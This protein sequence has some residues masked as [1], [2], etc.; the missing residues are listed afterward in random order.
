MASL[1]SSI[2]RSIGRKSGSRLN[3]LCINEDETFQTML[4]QTGHI[5]YYLSHPQIKPW[6]KAIRPIPSNCIFLSGKEPRDQLKQDIQFDIILCQNRMIQFQLLWK[7]ARQLSCPTII[8]EN[9]LTIPEMN[10]HE[11]EALANQQYNV[12]VFHSEFL[13]N[14][15]G[16]ESSDDDTFVVPYGID[17]DIFNGWVGEDGKILTIVNNYAQKNSITGFN[18]WSEITNGLPVNPRGD[19]KD[20]SKPTKDIRELISLYQNASV[21]LNTSSWLSCPKVLL[22]AMAIG[23]P[24]VTTATTTIPEIIIDGVNGYISHDN[25]ELRKQLIF[26]LENPDKSREL[27]ENAR[28]TII[29]KF[30]IKD[31]ISF[32]NEAFEH[33]VGQTSSTMTLS[34]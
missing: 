25:L 13:T 9:N 16:F 3:I 11:S 28:K 21:F 22:E 31:F 23:C 17:T 27:G 33:T 18:T 8:A 26:L 6:N 2:L 32:W 15:W 19:T 1:F 20:F 30:G 29:E 5:F 14:S 7:I 10:P 4:A 12:N 24:I 34:V